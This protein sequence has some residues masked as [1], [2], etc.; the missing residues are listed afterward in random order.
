MKLN[1]LLIVFSIV[2]LD[3][4]SKYLVTQ[5]FPPG[6]SAPLWGQFLYLTHVRNPGGAFG[7]LAQHPGIFII[8]TIILFILAA[9]ILWPLARDNWPLRLGLLIGLGGALGNF[10]DRLVHGVVIDF[11]DVRWWPVFNFADVA[12]VIGVLLIF[13]QIVGRRVD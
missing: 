6:E 12:I 7:F 5:N 8:S 9:F 11:I 10:I 2:L 1:E 3:Q 13:G 4:G